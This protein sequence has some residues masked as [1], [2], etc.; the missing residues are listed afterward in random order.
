M[1]P[2]YVP[3]DV[4]LKVQ[5]D[6]LGAIKA[7]IAEL[8]LKEKVIKALLIETGAELIRGYKYQAAISESERTT[9]DTERVRQYLSP[10]QIMEC[11][12]ITSV[13]T[14]RVSARSEG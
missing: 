11:T 8:Q 13:T 5:V 2:K 4:E 7:R 1:K 14:V 9:L 10:A 3:N 6:E 12:R